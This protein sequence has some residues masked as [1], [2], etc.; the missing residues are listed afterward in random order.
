M[1]MPSPLH[2]LL[3]LL[4]L[5]QVLQGASGLR[6]YT[7]TTPRHDQSSSWPGSCQHFDGSEAFIETCREPYNVC[8][9]V[10]L[11]DQLTRRCDMRPSDSRAPY[12]FQT[13]DL[14]SCTCPT[15]LCNSAPLPLHPSPASAGVLLLVVVVAF[16]WFLEGS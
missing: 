1:K 7:C 11:A 13:A 2:N 16:R 5:V 9:K 4:W 14:S 3:F 10:E 8:V 12:C 15:D 6:C